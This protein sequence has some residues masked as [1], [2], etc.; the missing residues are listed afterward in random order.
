MSRNLAMATCERCHSSVELEEAARPITEQEAG[1]YFEAYTG[2]LV[3]NATCPRCQARYLAWVR[4]WACEAS[5]FDLSYRSTF[6]DEPGPGDLPK[7]DLLVELDQLLKHVPLDDHDA[8]VTITR[9]RYALAECLGWE[10][11]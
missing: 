5:Y 7:P 6:N 3:A 8:T 10:K 4:A 2:M 9:A 11:A 1:P